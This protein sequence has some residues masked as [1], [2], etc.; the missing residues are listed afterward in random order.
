M[1]V[2]VGLVFCV[3]RR[4]DGRHH[5]SQVVTAATTTAPTTREIGRP[6]ASRFSGRV[7]ASRCTEI[8]LVAWITTITTTVTAPR[9]RGRP[10]VLADDTG[11]LAH[12]A[13]GCRTGWRSIRT[14][15]ASTRTAMGGL[16]AE[17][18]WS[19]SMPPTTSWPRSGGVP[20]RDAGE[21]R[22]RRRPFRPGRGARD[23]GLDLLGQGRERSAATAARG[24]ADTTSPTAATAT[25]TPPR[26][27]A[28][29]L[30]ALTAPRRGCRR[31]PPTAIPRLNTTGI[32][33]SG[34]ATVLGA[35][36]PHDERLRP[37]A[38]ACPT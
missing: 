32:S 2:H 17:R 23:R 1:I 11:G 13:G 16:A 34:G 5:P 26:A 6:R 31:R 12:A 15:P 33:A 35:G 25:T 24:R 21:Y 38:G 22:A 7:A 4:I 14:S 36:G 8:P 20:R 37:A 19:T 18:T 3:V 29:A 28:S 30:R 9:R 27:P 10:M